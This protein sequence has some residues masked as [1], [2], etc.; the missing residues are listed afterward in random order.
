MMN[1]L[2]LYCIG[3]SGKNINF[4]KIGIEE[5][6]VFTVPYKELSVV[7]HKSPYKV[8]DFPDTETAKELLEGHQ[9]VIDIA[10][11]K[12]GTVLPFGFGTFIQ[13]KNG[14]SSFENLSGWL[15]REQG[16]FKEKLLDLKGKVEYGMQIFWNLK[17]ISLKVFENSKELKEIEENI[18][19][20]PSGVA[21][22]LKRKLGDLLGKEIE[23]EADKTFKR[24]YKRIKENT[25]EIKIEKVKKGEDDKQMLMSLSC[26][27][28]KKNYEDFK[29]V[30]DEIGNES[31]FSIHLTGPWPPYSFV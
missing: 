4:G 16:N 24:F 12:F 8:Y 31:G 18:K 20:K 10:W 19:S 9:R 25:E 6:E 26:L 30:L 5:N 11:E 14:I 28:Y 13:D 15:E 27:L 29:K 23:K 21:Y 3:N 7:I 17:I 1:G 22:M 2:Y